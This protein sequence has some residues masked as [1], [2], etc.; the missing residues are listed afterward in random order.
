MTNSCRRVMSKAIRKLKREGMEIPDEAL[1]RLPHYRNE[2]INLLYEH[3]IDI[4]SKVSRLHHGFEEHPHE[5]SPIA[6]VG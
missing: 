4:P 6:F 3:T 2:H 5:H 1:R